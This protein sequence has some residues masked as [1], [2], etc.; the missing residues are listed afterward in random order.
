MRAKKRQGLAWKKME[1]QLA[2]IEGPDPSRSQKRT[3][4]GGGPDSN[5]GRI[6]KLGR[7]D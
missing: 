2:W 1:R 7:V 6:R 4:L 3:G 5:P